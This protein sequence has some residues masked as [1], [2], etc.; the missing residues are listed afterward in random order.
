MVLGDHRCFP[1]N[2]PLGCRRALGREMSTPA[3]STSPTTSH[4]SRSVV[5]ALRHLKIFSQIDM[6]PQRD[7]R[8]APLVPDDRRRRPVAARSGGRC[9]QDRARGRLN[10]G[11][12]TV[13][14]STFSDNFGGNRGGGMFNWGGYSPTTASSS[15]ATIPML[16]AAFSMG[17]RWTASA[18]EVV[19]HASRHVAQGVRERRRSTSTSSNGKRRAWV[20]KRKSVEGVSPCG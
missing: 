7:I 13:H 9:D 20:K 10:W 15:S 5:R 16:A 17:A 8:V 12:L 2:L 19:K 4:D 1:I 11:T 18:P 14:D 6:A 3:S